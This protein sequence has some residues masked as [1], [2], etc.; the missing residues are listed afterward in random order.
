MLASCAE[1]KLSQL[2]MYDI[3]KQLTDYEIFLKN[4][5]ICYS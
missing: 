2:R 1:Q 5:N 4:E 3:M